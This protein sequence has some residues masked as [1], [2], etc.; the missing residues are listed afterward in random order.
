M[1]IDLGG[2]GK[3]YAVDRV[4]TMGVERG[5]DNVLVD[6]GNDFRVYGQP[7]DK[8]AWHIGLENPNNPGTCWT[9]VALKNHAVASSGDYLRRFVHQGRRY[10]TSSTR[11]TVIR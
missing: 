6:F 2:I 8:V 7:P 3:G 1:S 5:I 9:G 11:A 4:L 10:G